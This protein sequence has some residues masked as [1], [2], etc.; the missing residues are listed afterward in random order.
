MFFKHHKKWI[1]LLTAF[2]F[3]WLI[4]VS[5]LPLRA[6]TAASTTRISADQQPGAIEQPAPAGYARKKNSPLIP[7]IIGVVVIGAVAAV[8]ILV[9]F[10]T[11]YDIRGNW[12]MQRTMLSGGSGTTTRYFVFTG[13]RDSGTLEVTDVDDIGTYTTSG[14]KVDFQQWDS[15]HAYDYYYTGQ[16]SDK[17]NMNGTWYLDQGGIIQTGTWTAICTL[18]TTAIPSPMTGAR[19]VAT[20]NDIDNQK[21]TQPRLNQI[22]V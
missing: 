9:V 10:K 21:Q 1:A 13:S 6:E 18:H 17:N 20:D 4:H 22:S 19:V 2:V 5:G 11:K 16:F 15:G 14:D 3:F 8:L 7:I 12:T